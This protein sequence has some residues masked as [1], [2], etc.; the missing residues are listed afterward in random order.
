MALCIAVRFAKFIIEALKD[1][2]TFTNVIIWSDATTPLTW[3]LA[4]IPH[5]QIFIRNRVNEMIRKI[6]AYKMKLCYILTDN[7]PADYLTKHKPDALTSPL[8][9]KGPD[10]LKSTADWI[11][12]VPSQ[13]M[14]DEIPVYVG[15][16]SSSKAVDDSYSIKVE[17][18]ANF[19][20]W[21]DLLSATASKLL[22]GTS[23]QLSPR[24]LQEAEILWLKELQQKHYPDVLQFL[25]Q[26]GGHNTKTIA[27]KK[28]IRE[29]KLV[30][31]SI[32]IN[33]NLFLDDKGIIRLY[34]CLAL[35]ETLAYD[36]RF[37]ILL[38]RDDFITKLLVL[39]HHVDEGHAGLQQT[40][41]SIRMRF[42]VPKLGKMAPDVI[43]SCTNCK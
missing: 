13:G 5:K 11:Q 31:P 32:C 18:I 39:Q 40:L 20:L 34:T 17:G 26:L 27:T 43:K 36:M 2:I 30:T 9:C 12:Y 19:K 10:I 38:P 22:V 8:W 37:P 42:W 7:N 21:D 24:H 41:S 33:L 3:V 28:I 25:Q 4:G 1:L 29:H 23:D 16:I 14:K 15:H 35:S 6:A